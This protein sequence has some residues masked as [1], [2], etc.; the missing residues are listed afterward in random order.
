MKK[1]IVA[2]IGMTVALTMLSG[3]SKDEVEEYPALVADVLRK[4][5]LRQRQWRMEMRVL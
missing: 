3:C 1:P 2:V 4:R 5:I